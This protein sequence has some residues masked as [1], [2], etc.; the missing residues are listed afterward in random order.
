MGHELIIPAIGVNAV[1]VAVGRDANGSMASPAGWFEIGWYRHGPRPGYPGSAAL[2]G[3]L[4]TNT[5]A[6]AAFWSLNQLIPG[7]EVIY[8]AADG[9][10]LTFVV[11]EVTSYPWDQ[12]PLDRVFARGGDPRVALITCGGTWSRENRNYS[13]RTIA[14]GRLR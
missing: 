3:H 11:E 14:Y 10:R 13:L 7:S 2:A 1:I 5:G 4:D 6:P 8:Q 12:V 9:T